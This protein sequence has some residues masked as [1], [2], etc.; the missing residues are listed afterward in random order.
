MDDRCDALDS[1]FDAS[2]SWLEANGSRLTNIES[3][4]RDIRD[5]LDTL[6][7]QM[8]NVSGFAKEIDHLL[9]RVAA[10]PRIAERLAGECQP[11]AG[12]VQVGL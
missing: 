1:R 9:K 2:D 10:S 12:S 11:L 4:L 7:M 3:E 6:D 5:R 8:K